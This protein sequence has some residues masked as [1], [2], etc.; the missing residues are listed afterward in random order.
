MWTEKPFRLRKM[1]KYS[2]VMNN[3][4]KAHAYPS[5]GYEY[6]HNSFLVNFQGDKG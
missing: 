3:S 2:L 5:V 6:F 4:S 1:K